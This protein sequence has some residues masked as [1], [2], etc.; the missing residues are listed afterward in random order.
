DLV[1]LRLGNPAPGDRFP[2]NF[3]LSAYRR[4]A[5]PKMPPTDPGHLA[6]PLVGISDHVWRRSHQDARRLLL[7]RSDLHV[8]S[9]RNAAHP[10][11]DQPIPAFRAPVVSQTG[12]ALEPLRRI[13]RA[14]VFLWAANGPPHRRLAAGRVSN[15][16]DHQR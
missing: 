12:N 8:L 13:D 1:R 16:P 11:S 2:V 9:L 6:V 15:F 14:V 5:I 7:A 3:S 10:E 4:A